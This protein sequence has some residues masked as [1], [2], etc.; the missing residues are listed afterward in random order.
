MQGKF[1]SEKN[2]KFLLYDVF[3]AQSLCTHDHYSQHTKKMFDMVLAEAMKL[4]KNLYYPIFEEMDRKPPEY[5]NGSVL[6]HPQVRK[7]MRESGQGGWIGA[8]FPQELGGDQLPWIVAGACSYMFIA[9]N[10]SASVYPEL[11]R[12]AANLIASYGSEALKKEYLPPMLAGQFQGT[13]ALTEPEAGSSLADITTTAQPCTEGHYSISGQKVFISGGD[14]DGVDNVI[15][16]ML[17]RIEG[18]PLGVKGISLFVVPKLRCDDNENP[19]PNDVVVSQ[20]YHKMGY[21][22]CPI[23]QLVMGEK[24]D[25]RGY[26][27]GE[28]H[29]GLFYMFQMMNESR[30]GVGLGATGI[31]SAA[32][33]AALAYT[34]T[35]KQG[36][37]P[38]Q[39]DPASP[40]VPIIEHADVKRMLLYQRSVTEGALCLIMQC[41]AYADMERVSTGPDREKYHLLLELLT[42]VA[43]TFPSEYG[44]LSVSQSLQCFG[45]YGYCEDFPVEQLY[46]DARIHPIHEGTTA[47]QGMDILGRKVMMNQ[48][49]AYTLFLEEVNKALDQAQT[50]LDLSPYGTKLAQALGTLDRVTGHLMDLAQQKNTEIFLADAVLYLDLF[51]LVAL[52]WQWLCQALAAKKALTKNPSQK[53]RDFY[54][55]K[56]LCFRYF[57]SYELPKINALAERLTAEDPIS[58]ECPASYFND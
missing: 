6:V 43:K 48:G 7:I 46:R 10:Y 37:K 50:H 38:G 20:I 49:K 17:A 8:T 16:L 52:S 47:I 28:P 23:T 34:Q 11:T 35:R 42:P 18:A 26:L 1:A 9:A 45:G 53:D 39:K 31:A 21:R 32:Y 13:M 58:V 12:G 2:V 41:Y 4:A 55:G 14:H 3:D 25:C 30:L 36:R 19:V 57:V 5:K 40:M 29:K 56:V 24:G 44:I 54:E 15:H 51:S 27:V 22:G 33:Y